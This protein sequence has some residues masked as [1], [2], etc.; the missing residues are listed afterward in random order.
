[1]GALEGRIAIVTGAGRGI[2]RE[3]ALLL[4]R[5]GARVVVNDLGSSADGVG[6]DRAAAQATVE[7]IL[8]FG[9]E[10]VANGDDVSSEDGSSS[11]VAQ[12]LAEFGNLHVLV[13]NAGI[14]RD[15]MVVNMTA[16]E[17]GDVMRT[18]LSGHFHPTRAAARYWREESKAGRQADRSIVHTTSTSGL[19][20]N[21]GQTNYGAAKAGIASFTII[22]Q[23]ELERYGVR[24]NAIAPN[25]RTRLT[26]ATAG[27]AERIA[28]PEHGFDRFDPANIAPFV[29]YLACADCPIKGRVFYVHANEVHLLRP[30]SVADHVETEGRWTVAAL[31]EQAARLAWVELELNRPY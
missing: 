8:A 5:E 22:C 19:F 17:W 21:A 18:H 7:E 15:R 25:A 9:G 26:L 1:V 2:G 11:L 3:H 20:G 23:M 6:A 16:D 29:A 31:R 14:L 10:A 13:N 28:P 4:A 12:A 24:C 27:V 30:W